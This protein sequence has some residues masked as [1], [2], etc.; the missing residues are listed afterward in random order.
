[1]TYIVV[2]KA[3]VDAT[4]IIWVIFIVNSRSG[5]QLSVR[6]WMEFLLK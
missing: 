4:R 1:M 5:C 3:L 6:W 2:G